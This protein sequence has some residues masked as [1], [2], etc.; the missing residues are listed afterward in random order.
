MVNEKLSEIR[1]TGRVIMSDVLLAIFNLDKCPLSRSITRTAENLHYKSQLPMPAAIE[2][3]LRLHKRD[4]G[5]V[6]CTPIDA[7]GDSDDDEDD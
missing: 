1:K 4:I 7:D 6:I 5:H 3:S 2:E